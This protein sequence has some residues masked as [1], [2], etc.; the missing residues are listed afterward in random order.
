[1]ERN[2][3]VLVDID[4]MPIA[5]MDKLEAHQQG[6]LHRAF[7]V[8]IFN[9]RGELL[10]QQRA[11]HKYHGANLWSNTCCSHPQWG[12][13]VTDSAQERLNYEMGI[14]CSLT[15]LYKF[16]YNEKVENGLIEHELDYIFVGYSNQEPHINTNEV[17]DYKWI[18]IENIQSDIM[19]SPS[20]YTIWFKQTIPY[21]LNILREYPKLY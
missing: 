13:D 5:E 14:V 16:I 2:K 11:S 4:D 20:H 1:M 10:I 6:K 7:S 3:V 21:L 8:F 15:G 18:S 9:D 19:S 17:K 12:E